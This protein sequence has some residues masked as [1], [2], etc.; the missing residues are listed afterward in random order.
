MA[1]Q[2]MVEWPEGDAMLHIRAITALLTRS[3]CLGRGRRRPA[4]IGTADGS[5]ESTLGDSERAT[6][7]E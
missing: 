2:V 5:G 7:R 1:L 4:R 6:I 3:L